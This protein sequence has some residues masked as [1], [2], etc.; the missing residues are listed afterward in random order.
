MFLDF[1]CLDIIA[2]K[3]GRNKC[4]GAGLETDAGVESSLHEV[5]ILKIYK[6]TVHTHTHTHTHTHCS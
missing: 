1:K 4:V 6:P 5:F 3:P 2:G